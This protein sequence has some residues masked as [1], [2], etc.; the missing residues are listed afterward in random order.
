MY[1]S[2]QVR[3]SALTSFLQLQ[4]KPA[5]ASVKREVILAASQVIMFGVATDF[6]L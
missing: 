6:K 3:N 4:R 1:S 2:F 5:C